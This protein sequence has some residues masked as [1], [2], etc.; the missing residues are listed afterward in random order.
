VERPLT[1][2]SLLR[3]ILLV[4]GAVVVY[5]HSIA[6]GGNDLVLVGALA[7]LGLLLGTAAEQTTFLRRR[8]DGVVLARAG[9]LA[10]I[11]WVLGM[12]LRFAFLLWIS[13]GGG[14]SL[15]HFSATHAI[16]SAA[17]SPGLLAMAVGEVLGRS[18]LLLA[19]RHRARVAPARRTELA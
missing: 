1:T 2:H 4:A 3:P 7:L 9:W 5:L 8:Q 16:T 15:A 6:T 11:C 13:H 10:G 12:G 14:P 19:R 18:A 17:W